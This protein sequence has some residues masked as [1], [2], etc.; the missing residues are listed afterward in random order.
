MKFAGAMSPY[1]RILLRYGIG[2][3]A[4]SNVGAALALD[5]DVVVILSLALG[6]GVESAYELAKRK[7][8][9]T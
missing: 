4:G 6:F 5:T 1:A 3:F 9:K 8:W 2:Y 7:G